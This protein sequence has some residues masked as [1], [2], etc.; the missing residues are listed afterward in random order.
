[1]SRRA[2]SRLDKRDTA[3]EL[4]R[5][6]G[7]GTEVPSEDEAPAEDEEQGRDYDITEPDSRKQIGP[8]DCG[9]R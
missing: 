7:H 5:M 8:L 3:L 9:A 1:M 6:F 2:R 4:A